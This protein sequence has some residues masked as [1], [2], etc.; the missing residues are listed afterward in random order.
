MAVIAMTRGTLGKD[1]AAGLAEGLGLDVIHHELIKPG[2]FR[3]SQRAIPS[4]I[5]FAEAFRGVGRE[6]EIRMALEAS[7]QRLASGNN[8]WQLGAATFVGGPQPMPCCR[9]QV[10][11]LE[12]ASG[13]GPSRGAHAF[14]GRRA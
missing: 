9:F 5:G 7:P 14:I 3:I 2:G 8:A 11:A 13:N 10:L 12:G 6:G 4:G 1:V